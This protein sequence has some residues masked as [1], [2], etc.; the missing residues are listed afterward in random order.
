MHIN[1]VTKLRQQM[2][3]ASE[4][5]CDF[6]F[7]ATRGTCTPSDPIRL[8]GSPWRLTLRTGALH[9]RSSRA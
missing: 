6:V 2:R 9:G 5:L 1:L 3:K 7:G 4:V 8:L